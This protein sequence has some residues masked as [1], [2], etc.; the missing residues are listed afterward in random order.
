MQGWEIVNGFAGGLEEPLV[1]C[2]WKTAMDAIE[3]YMSFR[4]RATTDAR[5]TLV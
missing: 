2:G 1:T 3:R 5:G 4:Q